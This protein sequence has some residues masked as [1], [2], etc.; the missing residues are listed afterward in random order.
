MHHYIQDDNL[1]EFFRLMGA[2]RAAMRA[3]AAKRLSG[4]KERDNSRAIQQVQQQQQ[5]K[6]QQGQDKATPLEEFCTDLTAKARE[7]KVDPVIGR[8]EEVERVVQILARRSKNN[9]I[10]LGKAVQ[11]DIRLTPR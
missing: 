10:L 2:D 3:E 5:Q 6:G 11:V 7:G 8:E 4:E 9:P 1:N